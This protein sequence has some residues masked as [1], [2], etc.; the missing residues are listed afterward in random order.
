[1]W[2]DMERICKA[3]SLPFKRPGTFPRNGLLASRIACLFESAPWIFDFIQQV[4]IANFF[5]DSDISD[6][7]VISRILTSLNLNSED[8]LRQSNSE[9]ARQKLRIQTE[10][11]Q[12]IGIFGAP[13][14]MIGNEMFWGHDRIEQAIGFALGTYP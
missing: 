1:M 14:L 2:R 6:T 13:T 8:I 3:E 5:G 11:A 7:N 12:T 4:F 10:F 9:E